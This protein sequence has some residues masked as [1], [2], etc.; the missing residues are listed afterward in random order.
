[1]HFENIWKYNDNLDVLNLILTIIAA[2]D[3]NKNLA[4]GEI[5]SLFGCDIECD[6]ELDEEDWLRTNTKE[7]SNCDASGIIIDSVF[8]LI[9]SFATTEIPEIDAVTAMGTS[10]EILTEENEEI[11]STFIEQLLKTG[12]LQSEISHLLNSCDLSKCNACKDPLITE[13]KIAGITK[14]SCHC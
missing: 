2:Y 9:D 7:S 12:V 8:D 13:E 3:S 6:F 4:D 5:E 14:L 10:S 11:D 1:M